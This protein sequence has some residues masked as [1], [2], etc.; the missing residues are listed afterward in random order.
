MKNG[1]RNA[2][3]VAQKL[4]LDLIKIINYKFEVAKKKKQKKEKT[5]KK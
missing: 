3:I 1:I 5:I 2:N 4:E